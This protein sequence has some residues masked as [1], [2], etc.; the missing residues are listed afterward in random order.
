MTK[1][2]VKT[3]AVPPVRARLQ[4]LAPLSLEFGVVLSRY[5]VGGVVWLLAL[6]L[7]PLLGVS[8]W[9]LRKLQPELESPDL[10][11]RLRLA[12]G[13][14][15]MRRVFSLPAVRSMA[16]MRSGDVAHALFDLVSAEIDAG[17]DH[18]PEVTTP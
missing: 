18:Y 14:Q 4:P 13:Q 17:R 5:H 6:E 8:T 1:T 15:H 2:K 12:E 10:T 9:R 7:E 11:R 16:L 3:L